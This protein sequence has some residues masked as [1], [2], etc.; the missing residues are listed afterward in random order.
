VALRKRNII[1]NIEAPKPNA[2]LLL[3]GVEML[4]RKNDEARMSTAEGSSNPQ[5]MKK[6]SVVSSSH[7]DFVIS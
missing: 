2:E 1:E 5:M 7:S 4:L 6:R 3:S